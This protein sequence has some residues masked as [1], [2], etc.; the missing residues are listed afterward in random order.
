M[1]I[2]E[3]SHAPRFHHQWLPDRLQLEEGFA[4]DT[5]RLLKKM[6]HEIKVGR[7]MG[8]LQSVMRT[9]DGFLGASDPRRP[10]ALTLGY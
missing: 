9:K 8:S 7:P 5:I 1:N 6:G 10:D 3:A 2:A 4:S